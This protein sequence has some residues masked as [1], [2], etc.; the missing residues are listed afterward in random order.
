MEFQPVE[1]L[2]YPKKSLP[3]H[4]NLVPLSYFLFYF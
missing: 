3:P 1:K 2:H 4:P